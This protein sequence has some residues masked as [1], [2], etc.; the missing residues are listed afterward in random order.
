MGSFLKLNVQIVPGYET[1]LRLL[2]GPKILHLDL[3]PRMLAPTWSAS[4]LNLQ[5]VPQVLYGRFR[6]MVLSPNIE[7]AVDFILTKT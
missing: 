1:F 4:L 7:P 2:W 3:D 6:P 5:A